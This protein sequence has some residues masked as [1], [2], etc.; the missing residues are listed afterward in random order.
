MCRS[1]VVHISR[2]PKEYFEIIII[3]ERK[4]CRSMV[5]ENISRT[6]NQYFKTIFVRALFRS[7]FYISRIWATRSRE[8]SSRSWRHDFC[9]VLYNFRRTKEELSKEIRDK[10]ERASASQRRV[11]LLHVRP[12]YADIDYQCFLTFTRRTPPFLRYPFS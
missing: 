9:Q 5:V 10:E 1:I 7:S 12:H 3:S 11:S 4:T 2:I 6:I 8:C